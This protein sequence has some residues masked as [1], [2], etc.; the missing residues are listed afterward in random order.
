VNID[1]YIRCKDS[2]I[3]AAVND[4]G[5]EADMSAAAGVAAK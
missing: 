1:D 5:E 3:I 4:C 2:G